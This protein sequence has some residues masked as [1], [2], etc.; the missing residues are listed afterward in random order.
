MKKKGENNLKLQD[1][2]DKDVYNIE[3][4]KNIIKKINQIKVTSP[5]KEYIELNKN[6]ISKYFK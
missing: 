6:F 3:T 2:N 1:I 4:N 5:K